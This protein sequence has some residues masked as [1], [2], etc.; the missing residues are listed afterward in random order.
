MLPVKRYFCGGVNEERRKTNKKAGMEL[1]Y[2]ILG[3]IKQLVM[4][5]ICGVVDC[6]SDT[7]QLKDNIDEC[8]LVSKFVF[9]FISKVEALMN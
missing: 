9:F 7:F 2:R 5:S 8:R 3:Y 4:A 6:E 1:L